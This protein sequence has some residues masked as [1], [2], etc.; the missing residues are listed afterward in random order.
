[1]DFIWKLWRF[2]KRQ[3]TKETIKRLVVARGGAREGKMRRQSTEDF[4]G[5]GNI[6]WCREGASVSLHIWPEPLKV[7][8]QDC[9]LRHITCQSQFCVKVGSILGKQM[10]H[11]SQ[12]CSYRVRRGATQEISVS[13][14][15]FHCKSKTALKK[16]NLKK[17][18]GQVRNKRLM[19]PGW[20][21]V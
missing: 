8:H 16:W 5:S 12:W 7:H 13:V 11:S 9:A 18:L 10:C 14:S 3:D 21:T 6:V 4:Q 2:W 17:T 20:S 15:Q 19:A 1:M